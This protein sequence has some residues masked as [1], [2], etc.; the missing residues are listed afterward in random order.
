MVKVINRKN[1]KK[2]IG[3]SEKLRIRFSKYFNQ[4]Q[5]VKYSCMLIYRALIK[6]G[7]ENFSLLILEYCEKE[8]CR[9]REGFYIKL[10]KPEYNVIQD[11]I[12]P[13][14]AGR[15]HS[16]ETLEKLSS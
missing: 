8:E 15:K 6:H 5:L 13:I 12:A 2:Y 16:N 9:K 10:L 14:F 11:P 4:N 7:Y 3:S 1:N